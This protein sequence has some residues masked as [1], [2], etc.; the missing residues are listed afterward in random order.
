MKCDKCSRSA[1]IHLTEL[2]D[3]AVRDV[4]LCDECARERPQFSEPL[5]LSGLLAGLSSTGE[6]AVPGPRAQA[7][8]LY[9]ES[10]GQSYREFR[11]N[12]R[13]GCADC[14]L[15]FAPNL[16]GVLKN[17]HGSSAHA[18]KKPVVQVPLATMPVADEQTIETLREELSAAIEE[19]NFE[20]AAVL[21]D[22]IR[23][24]EKGIGSD[25]SE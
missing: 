22:Q 3:G 21:R 11:H 23:E 19:E 14:Y 20:Q 24:R 8:D 18:G 15:A 1:T 16:P 6:M 4:Y 13:F 17:I 12:G 10:C 9:C 7:P 2:V 5:S 25:E